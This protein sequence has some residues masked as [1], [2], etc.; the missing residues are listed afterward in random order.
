[1]PVADI[2]QEFVKNREDALQGRELGAKL[3][4][5]VQCRE[6]AAFG[7]RMPPRRERPHERVQ[8]VPCQQVEMIGPEILI[9]SITRLAEQLEDTFKRSELDTFQIA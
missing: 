6:R 1:M 8:D 7:L 5:G 2:K 4:G 3:V 9:G